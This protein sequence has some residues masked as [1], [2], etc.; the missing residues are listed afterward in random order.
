MF[1]ATRLAGAEGAVSPGGL[2]VLT[3]AAAWL[4]ALQV[5]RC[6]YRPLTVGVRALRR[7]RLLGMGGD[8][9]ALVAS[10]SFAAHVAAEGEGDP[11]FFLSHRYYLAKG[12]SAR[13]RLQAALYHYRHQDRAFSPDYFE[14]VYRRGGLPLWRADT[15]GH[16][17]DILLQPGRDV[18]Y[19]GGLS[20]ALRADGACLC[21]LSFS[22]V[23]GRLLTGAGDGPALPAA[24]PFISRKHLTRD[25]G[26]QA[27]YNR[28]FHRVTP[29]HM[30]FAAFAGLAMAQGQRLALGIA[31]ARHP[32]DSAALGPHF[33]ASYDEFWQ[34]LGGRRVHAGDYLIALPWQLRPLEG[35]EAARRKR[36]LA[37]RAIMEEV[38]QSALARIAPLLVPAGETP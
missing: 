8:F 13:A 35:I 26:Y 4:R 28:A 37:R 38:R 14:K 32:S 23:P 2:P 10:P 12:L 18:A 6:R 1:E 24:L 22:Q 30:V 33:R 20:L 17:Y 31:P 19:E 9:A 36:A 5:D 21:V 34:S 25:H 3:P 29:A 7:S 11:L 16:R 15:G 27:P